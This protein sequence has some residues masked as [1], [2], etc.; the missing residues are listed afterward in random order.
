MLAGDEGHLFTGRL[1]AADQ[2]WLTDHAVFGTVLVPGTGLLE[3]ALAA[4]QRTGAAG[5]GELTILE[6]LVLRDAVRLQVKVAAPDGGSNR[7]IDIHSRPDNTQDAAAW[8][9]H[10]TGELTDEHGAAPSAA[11]LAELAQ[12]PVAGTERVPL[13]GFYDGCSTRAWSTAP[14]SRD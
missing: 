11:A 9:L 13:D 8:T 1:S 4:A 6:P 2:P 5:I 12:W 10:A 7:T 14:R 3:L